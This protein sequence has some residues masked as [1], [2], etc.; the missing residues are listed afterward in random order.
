[1]LSS[2]LN[3]NVFADVHGCYTV[4]SLECLRLQY[5]VSIVTQIRRTERTEKPN[6]M[7]HNHNFQ[8]PTSPQREDSRTTSTTKAASE[9]P[10]IPLRTLANPQKWRTKR[11][12]LSICT[13]F[14]IP[15]RTLDIEKNERR[16]QNPFPALLFPPLRNRHVQRDYRAKYSRDHHFLT[17]HSLTATC[18]ASAA[19]RTASSRRRTTAP[20]RSASPRLTRTAATPARTRPTLSADL[21][22]LAARA[23]TA[24]TALPSAMGS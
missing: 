18:R 7:T 17:S 11:E 20:F 10:Q 19:P 23:T 22:V 13:C 3:P 6:H 9:L 4:A 12:R 21:S 5:P 14:H 15:F 24:S 2:T 8:G 16:G 1:M